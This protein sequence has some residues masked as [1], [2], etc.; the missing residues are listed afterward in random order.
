MASENNDYIYIYTWNYTNDLKINSLKFV[1]IKILSETGQKFKTI[2]SE[3]Y[4]FL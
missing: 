2:P 4:F 3:T 1:D